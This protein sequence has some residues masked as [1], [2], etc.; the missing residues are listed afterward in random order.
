MLIQVTQEHI[1]KGR[2]GSPWEC[3]V[4]RAVTAMGY[5]LEDITPAHV[6]I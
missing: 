6:E 1:T 2:G 4:A 3:P 5:G